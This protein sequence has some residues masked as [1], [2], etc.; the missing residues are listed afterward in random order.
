MEDQ[1]EK[2]NLKKK[3]IQRGMKAETES[4][5]TFFFFLKD[6]LLFLVYLH[7]EYHVLVLGSSFQTE[8]LKIYKEQQG[9]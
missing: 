1:K 6:I 7:L 4:A 8:I 3:K 9:R 2:Q 5:I